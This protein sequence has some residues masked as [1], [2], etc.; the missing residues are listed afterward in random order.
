MICQNCNEREAS[1]HLTKIINGDKTEVYLCDKC[2]KET[3]QIPFAGNNPFAFQNLLKGILNPN[4]SSYD[5][6]S[7]EIKCET[8]GLSYKQFTNNGLFGCSDC[9]QSFSNKLDPLM[10]RIHG[11]INYNGKVPSR[12]GSELKAKREIQDLRKEMQEA[13]SEENFEKAAEIRDI[14]KDKEDNLNSGGE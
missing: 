8:C 14:I 12:R 5:Q 13:V 10:K 2:A 3:G 1:V 11:S 6:S 4:Q 9:Y 7:N